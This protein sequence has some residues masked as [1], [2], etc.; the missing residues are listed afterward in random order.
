MFDGKKV[1]KLRKAR[2][3]TMKALG[4]RLDGKAATGINQIEHTVSGSVQLST[5]LKLCS[6][7][8]CR[9]EDLLTDAAAKAYRLADRPDVPG[10][11]PAAADRPAPE[12]RPT[13][14]P[15]AAPAT[16]SLL[17]RL[18]EETRQVALRW[19]AVYDLAR[20]EADRVTGHRHYMLPQR[21][22]AEVLLEYRRQRD[23]ARRMERSG[24]SVPTPYSDPLELLLDLLGVPPDT[25]G[26]A[27]PVGCRGY[28]L[29]LLMQFGGT[30]VREAVGLL[31]RIEREAAAARPR[32]RHPAGGSTSGIGR[33]P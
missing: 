4:K 5:V 25:P 18:Q 33:G 31:D 17:V 30:S 9:F 6:A 29:E 28:Y 23:K 3:W 12:P 8:Q 11:G 22:A 19:R 21:R 15:A 20:N 14:P 16:E 27:N 7:L 24:M 2:R 13:P 10:A 32:T 26:T 1:A